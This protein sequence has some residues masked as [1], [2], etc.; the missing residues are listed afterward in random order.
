MDPYFAQLLPRQKLVAALKAR[1]G[2]PFR[3]GLGEPGQGYD[4]WHLVI[5]VYDAA[6]ID[7]RQ[8]RDLPDGSLN[9][10][11]FHSRSPLLEFLHRNPVCR[12][13][14]RRMDP[15]AAVMTGDLLVIR[16]AVSANHLAIAEGEAVAW[17]VPR[18]GTVS[19]ISLVSLV[20]NLHCIYRVMK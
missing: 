1:A 15:D 12:R 20:Q 11:R 10:G 19:R 4:C 17:H 14:L 5:D 18:G 3:A 2:T 9:H 8:L 7:T 6:G 16:Q 13:R